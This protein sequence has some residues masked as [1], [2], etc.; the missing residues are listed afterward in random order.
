MRT[1][2]RVLAIL[3]GIIVLFSLA[4]PVFA[5]DDSM[6]F[7]F[8]LTA[9][10]T[11]E[12]YAQPGDVITVT[13]TVT[14]TDSAEGFTLYSMQDE[15]SYDDEFFEL[16]DGSWMTKSG[17]TTTDIGL[18]DGY[19]SFYMNRVSMGGGDPWEAETLIGNFQLRV[20]ATSGTS[21]I[22][23]RNCIIGNQTGS[24]SYVTNARNLKVI[25]SND[26][27]VHFETYK[28]TE[29]PDQTV[30]IGEKVIRPE[31]PVLEGYHLEHWYRDWYETQIWDFD[32]DV[33]EGNMTLFAGWAEGD[34]VPDDTAPETPDGAPRS[35]L[36]LWAL[37]SG[38]G[39]VVL[40]AL[41]LMLFGGKRITVTLEAGDG[42]P[43]RQVK[44]RKGRKLPRPE[45]P[46]RAGY[47]LT[48]W[49]RDEAKTQPWKFR[50]DTVTEET[51]LYAGW[52]KENGEEE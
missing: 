5:A 48:G 44:I 50:T 36:P 32:N 18:M 33:V 20:I 51:T 47:R 28:G 45:A 7:D 42:S 17:I 40:A 15:I 11:S 21:I 52:E 4:V 29:I 26:C 30:S 39:I 3:F 35:S 27:T 14:R 23:N 6:A 43:A 31:D 1:G 41:L 46:E 16:I 19:R 10:G 2:K 38:A 22:E 24:A 13:L 34:P 49:Y 9:D 12:K 37:A 25:V 8:S